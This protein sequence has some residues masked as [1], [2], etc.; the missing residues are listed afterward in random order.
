MHTY[1]Y[2]QGRREESQLDKG[3]KKERN[4]EMRD[5]EKAEKMEQKC[6]ILLH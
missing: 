5:T 4:K 3:R 2:T 6:F 1:P